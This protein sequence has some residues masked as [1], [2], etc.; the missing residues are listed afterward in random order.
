MFVEDLGAFLED[1]GIEV[2][3]T[4]AGD[5]I[6]TSTLIHDAPMSEINVYDRSFYDEKFYEARVQGSAVNLLG[7]AASLSEVQVGD[8]A[9]VNAVDW[10]VITKE[11]DGT[12]FVTLRLSAN[13]I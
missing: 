2:V 12:G 8:V 7:V 13:S 9:T 5:E 3:F 11:P 1:F 4:R 10:Y 6:A